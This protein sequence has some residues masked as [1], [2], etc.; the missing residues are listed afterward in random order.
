[1][2]GLPVELADERERLFHDVPFEAVDAT[3]HA[4]FVISRVLDHGTIRSVAAVVRLYG[5]DRIKRFLRDGGWARVSPRT[6]ALWFAY[7]GM[8]EGECTSR[9]SP[10]ASSPYWKP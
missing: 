1:M 8:D 10:R 2:N 7:L 5:E 9:S 6:R 4:S 3:A